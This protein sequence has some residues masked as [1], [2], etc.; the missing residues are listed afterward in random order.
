MVVAP[1]TGA[2]IVPRLGTRVPIV[3][4]LVLQA[5]AM[6]WMAAILSVDEAYSAMVV[7]FLLAGIGMGLVFAPSSTAVL[8]GFGEKDHAKASGTNSTLREIGIALGVAVLTAVFIGAG[9]TL[10]PTGYVNAA[11]PAVIVGASVLAGAAVIGLFLPVG[12]PTRRERVAES[13][14]AADAPASAIEPEPV[15]TVVA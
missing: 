11:I 1:L 6:F 2:L 9:G 7:P 12:K 13:A 15:E 10:T 5:V 14:A 8:A 3:A 4:G